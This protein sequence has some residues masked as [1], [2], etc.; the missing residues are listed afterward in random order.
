M[1]QSLNARLYDAFRPVYSPVLRR[2]RRRLGQNYFAHPEMK[3]PPPYEYAQLE[4]ERQ[5]HTYLHTGADEISQI[6]IVGAAEADEVERMHAAYPNARFLCFEPNPPAFA[7]ISKKFQDSPR[8]TCAK[9]ALSDASGRTTFY[10]MELG[11][12][13]SI[14]KPD[15][16][17]FAT[18]N[19]TD[20]TGCKSFEVELS[21][22]DREAAAL[23]SIDL[24]WMD[25]QGAEGL[26][27]AGATETLKRTRVVFLEVAVVKSPYSGAM[28]F[29]PIAAQ[30]NAMGF[31]CVQL[32]LDGWNGSGNAMFVRDF[33]KLVCQR[34]P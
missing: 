16:G 32:G 8:V 13:G 14:L 27:L 12:N 21:T 20:Q 28:L 18:F 30:L 3:L 19:Q 29:A 5:L 2:L 22:L 24:L 10:E 23:R 15:A 4:A 26:V 1:N 25:V 31:T 17:E 6:V 7:H 34:R 9:L 11:G 33:E